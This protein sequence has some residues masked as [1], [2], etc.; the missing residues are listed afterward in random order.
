MLAPANN[1]AWALLTA[2]R[3]LCSRAKSRRER[4][5]D[6]RDARRVHRWWGQSSRGGG[7]EGEVVKGEEVEEEVGREEVEEEVEEREVEG[8]EGEE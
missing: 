4:G 2:E 7:G 5:K 1:A 3:A 8:E 6:A